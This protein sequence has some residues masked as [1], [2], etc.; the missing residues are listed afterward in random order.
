MGAIDTAHRVKE[1]DQKAPERDELE[2]PFGQ[3]IV[4]GGGAMTARADCH[5]SLAR[6]DGDLDALAI[7][8]ESG[9]AIDETSKAMAAV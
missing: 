6:V 4:T 3:L 1:K 8:T 2:S 7:G 5:R 9:L